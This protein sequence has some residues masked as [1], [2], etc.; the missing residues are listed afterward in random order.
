MT[1]FQCSLDKH[2][3]CTHTYTYM[4]VCGVLLFL[5]TDNAVL[6]RLGVQDDIKV[7]IMTPP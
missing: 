2:K 1:D 6:L 5:I 4:C 7:H 3:H